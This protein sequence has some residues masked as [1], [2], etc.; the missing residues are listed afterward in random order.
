MPGTRTRL[1]QHDVRVELAVGGA[2]ALD[3]DRRCH[4]REAYPAPS[5]TGSSIR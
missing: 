1:G 2:H 3:S 5:V 4:G